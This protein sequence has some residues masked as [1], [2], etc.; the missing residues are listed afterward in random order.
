MARRPA[1]LGRGSLIEG[2]LPGRPLPN[3]RR[4]GSL[5]FQ[6]SAPRPVCRYMHT[7]SRL[8]GLL[9]RPYVWGG[10]HNGGKTG[11][12]CACVW[13]VG[14]PAGPP[15]GQSACG[16][17]RLCTCKAGRDAPQTMGVR[18]G[19][20]PPCRQLCEQRG[21]EAAAGARGRKHVAV[22]PPFC[23]SP[24]LYGRYTRRASTLWSSRMMHAP[25]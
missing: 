6:Q 10:P 20:R 8:G 15:A 21:T 11:R 25:G 17:V 9:G 13:A 12:H 1:R 5:P 2:V 14:R 18:R 3:H 19:H 23:P 16:S 7:Y 4:N 24:P 22:P